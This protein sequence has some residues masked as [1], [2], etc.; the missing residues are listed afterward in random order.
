MHVMI[1]AI[2][3]A[4]NVGEAICIAN[5]AVFDHLDWVEFTLTFDDPRTVERWADRIRPAMRTNTKS[6]KAFIDLMMKNTKEEFMES[7]AV[8]RA[9]LADKDDEQA[10]L[11]EDLSW[12]WDVSPVGGRQSSDKYLYD[13]DA[14]PILNPSSL[15]RALS[16]IETG[17]DVPWGDG[18][19]PYPEELRKHDVW[20]VPCDAKIA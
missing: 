6:G 9:F 15:E 3:P 5:A 17:G 16:I 1:G 10:Y 14:N 2:V 8:L 20:V 4:R 19:M 12:R 11:H 18:L 13:W 7:I